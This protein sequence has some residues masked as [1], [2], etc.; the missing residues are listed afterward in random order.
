MYENNPNETEGLIIYGKV[1][2]ETRNLALVRVD[3]AN[4]ADFANG[5]FKTFTAYYIIEKK[6]HLDQ[7]YYRIYDMLFNGVFGAGGTEE[8]AF[9]GA[10]NNRYAMRDKE[11][12]EEIEELENENQNEVGTMAYGK[13]LW[14]TKNLAVII[15]NLNKD[16]VLYFIIEKPNSILKYGKILGVGNTEYR[17]FVRAYNNTSN[18]SER[19]QYEEIEELESIAF[20]W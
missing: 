13:L 16:I 15:I 6:N 8:D 10:Y 2:R 12:Y 11:I 17:A 7:E 19:E 14:E 5:V 4:G 1:L 18:M 20:R 3:F 9:I